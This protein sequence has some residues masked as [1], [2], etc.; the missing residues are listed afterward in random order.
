MHALFFHHGISLQEIQDV[1]LMECA[2]RSAPGK[3]FLHSLLWYIEVDAPVTFQQKQACKLTREAGLKLFD[4]Q[5][6]DSCN[7]FDERPPKQDIVDYYVQD[8]RK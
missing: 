2:S 8:V 5:Q 3:I 6:G 4:P 1:Q 7:V